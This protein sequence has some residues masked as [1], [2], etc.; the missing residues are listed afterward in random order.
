M[1]IRNLTDSDFET[2]VVR[3]LN[4]LSNNFEKEIENITKSQL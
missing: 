2:L 1:E 3:I 4:E